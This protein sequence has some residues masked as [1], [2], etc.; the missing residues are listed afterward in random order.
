M[1]TT[2]H[3]LTLELL[4]LTGHSSIVALEANAFSTIWFSRITDHSGEILEDFIS[5]NDFICHN[6]NSPLTTFRG[7]RGSTNIDITLSSMELA[8]RV[9]DW[10]IIADA[11]SSDHRVLKFT[12]S[13]YTFPA[14]KKPL[15]YNTKKANWN[16]FK[17]SLA[18]QLSATPQ[19]NI[20]SFAESLNKAFVLAADL[21]ITRNRSR[22]RVLRPWWSPTLHQARSNLQNKL[23]STET[24]PIGRST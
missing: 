13:T 5:Q 1:P 18:Q 21:A 22:S 17:E 7:T 8:T 20:D 19:E 12:L 14:V 15:R 9:H 16:L 24:W 23:Q 3:I 11:T 2:Q 4:S 10:R 6:A